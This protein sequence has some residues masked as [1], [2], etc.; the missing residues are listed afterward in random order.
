[1]ATP[2]IQAIKNKWP[3][4]PLFI[5]ALNPAAEEVFSDLVEEVVTFG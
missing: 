1:M 5:F 4:V 2:A 3:S